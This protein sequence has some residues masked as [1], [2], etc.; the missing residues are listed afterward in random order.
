MAQYNVV[1]TVGDKK[2]YLRESVL[3]KSHNSSNV[4]IR[5]TKKIM[6]E[7]NNRMNNI[8]ID[9]DKRSLTHRKGDAFIFT[10]EEANDEMNII[11]EYRNKINIES[12]A[13][14]SIE[15]K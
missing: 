2:F 14:I 5:R 7:L 4:F 6:N 9:K 13:E 8:S 1:L 3:N 15:E 11:N 10:S 12:S